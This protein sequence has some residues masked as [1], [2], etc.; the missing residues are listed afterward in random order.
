MGEGLIENRRGGGWM[1]CGCRRLR[2]VVPRSFLLDRYVASFFETSWIGESD[3]AL[4]LESS[5]ASLFSLLP[6]SLLPSC[7]VIV[8]SCSNAV[9]FAYTRP[10][11]MR[12]RTFILSISCTSST[13]CS[14]FSSH[15][16]RTMYLFQKTRNSPRNSAT[17]HAKHTQRSSSTST[18]R[19]YFEFG[20]W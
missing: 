14:S 4:C 7:F 10:Y 1:S 5:E 20:F 3:I 9:T 18:R 2:A 6:L 8:F 16:R 11:L 17:P 13:V 19:G 12:V 15:E